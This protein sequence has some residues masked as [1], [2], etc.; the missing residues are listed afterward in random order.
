MV[1]DWGML[2]YL[3]LKERMEE[4]SW[5]N[6]ITVVIEE[7]YLGMNAN[8]LS[9]LAY[10][11]GM[12]IGLCEQCE[13]PWEFVKPMHWKRYW[14]L[15]KLKGSAYDTYKRGILP[16]RIPETDEGDAYLIGEFWFSK[17]REKGE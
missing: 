8:T 1:V 11:V 13:I 9:K 7:P 5:D 10:S 6:K 4:W 16:S 15:T 2:R 14:G 17:K 12:V 3:E